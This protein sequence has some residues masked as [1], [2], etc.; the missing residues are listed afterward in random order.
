MI[1][2]NLNKIF[3]NYSGNLIFLFFVGLFVVGYILHSD[4]G[5]SLD[6]ESTRFHGIVSLNY[7]A[8]FFFP[9]QKFEFQINETIPSLAKYD[10]KIYGAFFEILLILAT[11]I[12]LGM[13]NLYV[14]KFFC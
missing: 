13:K 12:I 6:E 5:I 4:Y 9:S 3:I 10:Y 11:E 8:D 7:I 1:L 14:D 2:R